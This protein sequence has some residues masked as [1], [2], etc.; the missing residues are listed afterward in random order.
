LATKA[1]DTKKPE[2]SLFEKRPRNF[3]IGNDIQ[4]KRDLTRYVKWPLYVRLQRQRSILKKRLKVPPALNQFSRTLDKNTATQVFRL[5]SKYQPESKVEK[6][7]R[8]KT[9]AAAKVEGKEAPA[10]KKPV[11]VKY[12]LN[13]VTALV[14]NK[15]AQL[16]LIA[17]DVDPIELVVW[18]PSL[19]RKMGIPY[20]IVKSKSRLGALVHKKTA[21]CVAVTE[22]RP[23]NKPELAAVVQAIKANF[24]D[25]AEDIRK[26]WG[27][28]IM[29]AKSQAMMAK[30][31]AL[32]AKTAELRQ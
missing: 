31:A 23:E 6:K 13:H 24:N 2:H 3:S 12:G 18:L 8:L 30:R 19:C 20:A 25:K 15:K 9:I 32:R 16:V 22:V 1:K 4:P 5:L 29:G 11:M 28:G 17:H 21:A 14:E 7:D 27:G 26:H 10:N